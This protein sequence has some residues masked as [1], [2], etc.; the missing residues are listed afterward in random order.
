MILEI[1]KYGHPAL[2]S[3]GRKVEVIDEKIRKLAADMIDTMREAHGIG[4]AAQQVGLPLQLCVLEVH[5]DSEI[6]SC[7]I[8]EGSK[9]DWE[10]LMPMVL[11]NPEVEKSGEVESMV[12][13]CLSFP[14]LNAEVE[15]PERVKVRALDLQG[16][17]IEFEATGLLARAVQHEHDHLHG[18]LFID[19]M[20]P[21]ARHELGPIEP[22]PQNG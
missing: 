13:G 14:G 3:K 9:A 4:L 5:D 19:R 15:R 18:V 16:A 12:E 20:S 22:Y 7:M 17:T 10:R 6:P 11:I 21:Q 1:V 8:L 2:R